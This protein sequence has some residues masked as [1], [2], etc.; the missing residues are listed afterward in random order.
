MQARE[1]YERAEQVRTEAQAAFEAKLNEIKAANPRLRD[2]P[3]SHPELEDVSDEEL[4]NLYVRR[5]TAQ[6]KRDTKSR[7][8]AEATK[9]AKRL[10]LSQMVVES[11]EVPSCFTPFLLP[12]SVD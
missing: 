9:R 11:G 1:I 6:R 3:D 5:H 12:K 8:L 2:L 7:V 10:K 4:Q